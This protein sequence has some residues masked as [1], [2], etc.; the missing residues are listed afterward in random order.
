MTRKVYK[1]EKPTL[2][3]RWARTC[4]DYTQR[5]DINKDRYFS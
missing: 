5:L 2:S 4:V 3:S 1:C